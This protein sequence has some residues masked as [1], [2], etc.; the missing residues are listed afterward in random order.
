MM[1]VCSSPPSVLP[2]APS[3]LLL[4][5]H[6]THVNPALLNISSYEKGGF[7]ATAACFRVRLWVSVKCLETIMTV[8]DT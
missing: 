1:Y 5:Q 2:P 3:L 6:P 7:L 4:K 8:T